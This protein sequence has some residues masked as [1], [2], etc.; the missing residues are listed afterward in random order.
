MSVCAHAH[1]PNARTPPAAPSNGSIAIWTRQFDSGTSPR[2]RR[3]LASLR[4][5]GRR[6]LCLSALT[7]SRDVSVV[8]EA[9]FR[10]HAVRIPFFRLLLKKAVHGLEEESW[11]RFLSRTTDAVAMPGSLP[12]RPR[13]PSHC[14]STQVWARAP[15]GWPHLRARFPSANA[16]SQAP[17]AAISRTKCNIFHRLDR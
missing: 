13:R 1:D 12:G 2:A 5:R 16:A 6:G 9:W 3:A 4:G 15:G 17:F 7:R 14:F 11:I 8:Y 10:V